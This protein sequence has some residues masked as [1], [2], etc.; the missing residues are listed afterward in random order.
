MR[1]L[2]C[3]PVSVKWECHALFAVGCQ[4]KLTQKRVGL[5]GENSVVVFHVGACKG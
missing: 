2:K 4:L 1:I 3:F 5:M